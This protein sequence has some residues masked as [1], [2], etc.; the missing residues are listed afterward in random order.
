[1]SQTS[2]SVGPKGK[3]NTPLVDAQMKFFIP[4]KARQP[5]KY[6]LVFPPPTEEEIKYQTDEIDF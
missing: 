5:K 3:H 2:P 4:N 6:T 1:M